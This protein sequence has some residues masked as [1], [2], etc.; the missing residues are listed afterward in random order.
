MALDPSAR[1][2]GQVDVGA[3]GYPFGRARNIDTEGDGTGT[4]LEKDLVNDIF[5]FQQ[6]LLQNAGLTPTNIPDKVG[7]SQYL[8]AVYFAVKN[9]LQDAT[10]YGAKGDGLADDTPALQNALD[11]AAALGVDF[12]LLVAGIY[13]ITDKLIMPANVSLRCQGL[14]RLWNDT[15]D[16]PTLSWETGGTRETVVEGIQFEAKQVN[17]APAVWYGN[18]SATPRVTFIRCKVNEFDN[19]HRSRLGRFDSSS[20][21]AT[22]VDCTCNMADA[23]SSGFTGTGKL[24]IRGG[25]FTVP[26]DYANNFITTNTTRIYNASFSQLNSTVGDFAFILASDSVIIGNTFNVTNASA[27]IE[28]FAYA[29]GTGS[30]VTARGNR[31]DG[32]TVAF[33][34]VSGEAAIGSVLQ[35]RP[36]RQINLPS[37][38]TTI[39]GVYDLTTIVCSSAIKPSFDIEPPLVE[40]QRLALTIVNNHG[41]TDWAGA[42]TI[43]GSILYDTTNFADL[44]HG[45]KVLAQF[46]AQRFT[47]GGQLRWVQQSAAMRY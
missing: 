24:T 46:V 26:A 28:T 8:Q 11:A 27:P 12:V 7:S 21:R 33:R 20:S 22:L 47:A 5:G 14:A 32:E 43:T 3:T 1:Y 2:P 19:K 41:S 16:A 29:F 13:R 40:N 30:L 39:R 15:P 44:D 6:A 37:T 17:S 42:I 35:G 23:S 31:F 36:A 34:T 9:V 4:P 45:D 38:T 25:D 10:T 18:G